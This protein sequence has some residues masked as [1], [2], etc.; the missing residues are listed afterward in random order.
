[1]SLH[2][3]A[4]AVVNAEE[5]ENYVLITVPSAFKSIVTNIHS[6]VSTMLSL[7]Q[8]NA[9]RNNITNLTILASFQSI[10]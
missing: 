2:Y 5:V 8:N 6:F 4:E 10:N 7:V 9:N 1:M 3:E